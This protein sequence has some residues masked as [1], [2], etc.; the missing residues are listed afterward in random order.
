MTTIIIILLYM[1]AAKGKVS[2]TI[3]RFT[4]LRINVQETIRVFP[5]KQK[6]VVAARL[7]YVSLGDGGMK[8]YRKIRWQV[9]VY[10]LWFEL[11]FKG[12]P[13][14]TEVGRIYPKNY[15][16]TKDPQ[17]EDKI[18]ALARTDHYE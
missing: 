18:A 16:W 5:R 2:F 15:D 4:Y 17:H 9:I 8:N 11:A 12:W 7:E 3:A 6:G 14:L 10:W 1:I 13:I